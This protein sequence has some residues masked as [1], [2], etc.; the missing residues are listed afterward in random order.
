M[1]DVDGRPVNLRWEYD[2]AEIIADGVVHAIGI[3]LGIA[4]A[5][6][7]IVLAFR[8][9]GLAETAAVTIYALGL[10]SLFCCSAAYNLWPISPTKWWLR[11]FDHAAIFIL[12]AGTYTPFATQLRDPAVAAGLLALVWTVALVAA[13]L[14][15]LLPGRLDRASIA[16]YLLL[17][18][19]GALAYDAVVRD[20]SPKTLSL[21]LTGCA[22][23]VAGLVFH[24]WENLR[25]QNA[26]WHVFVLTASAIFYSAILGSVV[27]VRA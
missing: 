19:S 15:I 21:I 6:A 8:S 25:F 10:V 4:G 2:R 16:L 23:Y 26:V 18:G 7:I 9:S 20:L 22:I 27:L 11:R 1:V 3:A 24:L 12:I 14:K 13:A 17:G 5:I